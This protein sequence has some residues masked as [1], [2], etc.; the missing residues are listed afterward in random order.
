M[1]GGR[2]VIREWG[3]HLQRQKWGAGGQAICDR[4]EVRL[5]RLRLWEVTVPGQLMMLLG[6]SLSREAV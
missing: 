5:P 4:L 3:E 6:G 2:R 1:E